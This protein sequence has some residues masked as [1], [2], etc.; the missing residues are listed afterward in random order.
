MVNKVILVGR[1]TADPE[2]RTSPT[3]VQIAK[4]KLATNTYAGK[5]EQGVRKEHAEFHTL[6]CFGRL[7]EVAADYLKKGKLLYADGR[8]QANNWEDQ[9]GKKHYSTEIVLDS[10]QMLGP[11][12]AEEA[13]A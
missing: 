7:A 10:F 1:L 6:V 3:G 12:P 8:I 2:L 5:D 13:A 4:I 9:D 11:K